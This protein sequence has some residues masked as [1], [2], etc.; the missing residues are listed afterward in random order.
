MQRHAIYTLL[1][2]QMVEK[3]H[4]LVSDVNDDLENLD[5]PASKATDGIIQRITKGEEEDNIWC[6]LKK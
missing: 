5:V 4:N 1:P 2:Q 3:I 6:S